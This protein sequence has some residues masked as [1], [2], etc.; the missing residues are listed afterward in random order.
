LTKLRC[1]TRFEV[2][3]TQFQYKNSST[4]AIHLKYKERP[5]DAPLLKPR[6]THE[7]ELATNIHI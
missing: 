6:E 3:T 7:M 5:R 2:E 1:K 4:N